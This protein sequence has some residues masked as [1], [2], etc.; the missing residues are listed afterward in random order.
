[1][2]SADGIIRDPKPSDQKYG[3]ET[4]DNFDILRRF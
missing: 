3:L 4:I 2:V 1:M